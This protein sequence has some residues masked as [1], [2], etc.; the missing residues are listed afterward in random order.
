[1][2]L[3]KEMDIF[4]TPVIVISPA[5]SARLIPSYLKQALFATNHLY[6]SPFTTI[7]VYITDFISTRTSSSSRA[8]LS[9]LIRPFLIGR[10]ICILFIVARNSPRLRVPMRICTIVS[11]LLFMLSTLSSA[12]HPPIR[13]LPSEYSRLFF[14]QLTLHKLH[15]HPT[16]CLQQRMSNHNLHKPL[17]TLSP[18]LNHIIAESIRKH[19]AWQWRNSDAG[20]LALQ[21]VAEVFEVGVAAADFGVAHVEGGDVGAAFD[22]VGGVHWDARFGGMGYRVFHL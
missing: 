8:L 18:M 3:H 5:N 22:E 6:H 12:V 17:Q 9:Q 11:H 15:K 13:A 14:L 7:S 10:R 4:K 16:P 21:D 1:M 20:R 2:P 19:L